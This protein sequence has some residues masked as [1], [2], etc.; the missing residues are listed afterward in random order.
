[1]TLPSLLL[2]LRN[3][4]ARV[5]L[6]GSYFCAFTDSHAAAICQA[7]AADETR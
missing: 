4:L 7:Q 1:V 3:T 2:L 5:R 6:R